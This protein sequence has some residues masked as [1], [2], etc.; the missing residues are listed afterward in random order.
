MTASMSSRFASA[1][2]AASQGTGGAAVTC[3]F[4]QPE[5]VA[6]A[7]TAPETPVKPGITTTEFWQT[8]LTQLFAAA[9][10]IISMLRSPSG[11]TEQQWSES[12]NQLVPVLAA[13]L[14]AFG[15]NRQYVA[16]R[17]EVKVAQAERAASSAATSAPQSNPPT[18]TT[19]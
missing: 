6:M 15:A 17:T 7:E 19:T 14:A 11:H 9:V 2:R 5:F 16:A 13:L 4:L 10:A 3:S 12:V 18:A 8:T 1:P